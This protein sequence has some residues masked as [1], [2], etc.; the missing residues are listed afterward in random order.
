MS[1]TAKSQN[2]T[3][4]PLPDATDWHK[5]WQTIMERCSSVAR[6]EEG[7]IARWSEEAAAEFCSSLSVEYSDAMFRYARPYLTPQATFLDV[8][9]GPG[10]L[11]IPFAPHVSSATAV[12]CSEEMLKLVRKRAEK[13]GLSNVSCVQGFWR[14][15][16]P[17]ALASRPYD[18]AVSSNSIDLIAAKEI[19]GDD[20]RVTVDW[21]LADALMRLARH[22]RHV[23]VS[24]PLLKPDLEGLHRL[25]GR[26]YRGWPGPQIVHNVIYQLGFRPSVT[27]FTYEQKNKARSRWGFLPKLAWAEKLTPQE[28][29]L[30]ED[31]LATD[32]DSDDRMQ[33][34]ILMAWDT[35]L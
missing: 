33:L 11:A 24:M 19:P 2:H 3:A 14:D 12:D 21:N 16:S 26:E 9:C 1:D 20:G 10:T 22:S 13:D 28:I 18:L 5:E 6:S 15:L 4:V 27:Y 25:L 7:G 34:W 8:G 32:D 35:G 31:F 17:D 29:E 30:A 23:L